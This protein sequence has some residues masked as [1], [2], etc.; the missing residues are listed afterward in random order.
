MTAADARER[1][2]RYE[3]R[4]ARA[5]KTLADYRRTLPTYR[6]VFAAL[7]VFG[8]ACFGLGRLPGLWAT[9]SAV[10]ISG[11]GY[12]MLLGRLWEVEADVTATRHEIAQ[13]RRPAPP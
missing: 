4:A 5:D 11:G 13:L 8:V 12:A 6:R 9:V 1:I 3:A 7:L 10:V 2:A